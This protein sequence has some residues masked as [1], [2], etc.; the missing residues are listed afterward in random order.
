MLGAEA[1]LTFLILISGSIF[2]VLG[3]LALYLR[4]KKKQAEELMHLS[5]ENEIYSKELL[6]NKE[7][8]LVQ[9]ST[10]LVSKNEFI[11]N[12]SRDLEYHVSLV[13]N[14]NEKKKF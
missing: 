13:N 4:N 1:R 9:M 7:N 6:L 3:T 10:F 2:V 12:I 8:E 14:K 11:N 5:K